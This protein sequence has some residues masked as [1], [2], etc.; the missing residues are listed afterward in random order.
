MSDD[1]C[2]KTSSATCSIIDPKPQRPQ[3]FVAHIAWEPSGDR[4]L[5]ARWEAYM[6]NRE[7][8]RRA[9]R[10]MSLHDHK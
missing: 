4:T 7:R 5:V 9:A 3:E 1:R 6:R 8:L 10:F 2:R